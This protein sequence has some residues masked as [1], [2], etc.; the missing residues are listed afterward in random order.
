MVPVLA[1]F[2][3]AAQVGDGIDAAHLQPDEIGNREA[4][5]NADIE[6]AVGVEQSGI[7]T[8]ELQAFFVSD[9][10][11]HARAI[12]AAAEDL[13]G[14]V[15][16][17]V[18][19]DAGLAKD[20]ASAGFDIVTVNSAWGGETGEGVECFGIAA[21]AAEPA[22]RANAGQLDFAEEPARAEL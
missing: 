5:G 15:I 12:F 6:A 13:C 18:A 3:A 10:Y 20:A 17:R 19:L 9:K 22:D 11:R 1:V 21:L 8:V 4:R 2:A 14:L 16:V 7:F